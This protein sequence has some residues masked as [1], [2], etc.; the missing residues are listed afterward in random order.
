MQFGKLKTKSVMSKKDLIWLKTS[1]AFRK[2]LRAYVGFSIISNLYRLHSPLDSWYLKID[3]M[4]CWTLWINL[5]GRSDIDQHFM[6][7]SS[8]FWT[9]ILYAYASYWAS[10][11]SRYVSRSMTSFKIK[12]QYNLSQITDLKSAITF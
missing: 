8:N 12:G 5:T 1:D 4:S 11:L 9:H 2:I 7:S 3:I 6:T 10:H